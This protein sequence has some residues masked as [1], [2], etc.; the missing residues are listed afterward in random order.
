M[1]DNIIH[2]E[3]NTDTISINE[4][5]YLC[6]IMS[7]GIPT[8]TILS[9][10]LPGLGATTL[11]IETKRHSIIIEPNVPVIKGKEA[12]HKQDNLLGVYEGV[13]TDNVIDY[14]QKP[15]PKEKFKKIMTTPESFF[16]IIRAMDALGIDYKRDYM[17][18]IDECDK[19]IQDVD[20]RESIILPI[21]DFFL[22]E[23]KAFVSATPLLPSDPRFEQQN[24]QLIKIEPD[25]EYRKPMQLITT[26]NVVAVF[27][28][29][30]EQVEADKPLCIF[31]NS[32]DTIDAIINKFELIAESQVFCSKESVDKLK[33]RNS[34]I[35]AFPDLQLDKNKK[36]KLL[37]YNFF[38]SR[39]FSAVDIDLNVEPNVIIISDLF[40]AKHSMIDPYTEAIQIVGRFRNGTNKIIHLSNADYSLQS[41]TEEQLDNYLKGCHEVYSQLKGLLQSATDEGVRDTL[42]EALERVSYAKYI[43][44]YG[45]KKHFSIDNLFNDERIKGYYIHYTRLLEAYENSTFFDIKHQH[46]EIALGDDDR[47]K[48]SRASNKKEKRLLIME[49]LLLLN[50]E[51]GVYDEPLFQDFRDS[52]YN[53][54]PLFVEVFEELGEEFA[55]KNCMSDK[56]MKLALIK[57][58]SEQ[59]RDNFAIMTSIY[60][61]FTEGEKYTVKYI[62]KEIRAIFGLYGDNTP[63][64]TS[65]IED[66]FICD[67]KVY[68]GKQRAYF[69]IKKLY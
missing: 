20:Y 54:D 51:N 7:N 43:D 41:K 45:N 21:E 53:E 44:K 52:F 27:R 59:G 26:N 6:K 10:T 4:G 34:K 40:F 9:K 37:K 24:F 64:P 11:E 39:F 8:N 66:Y 60:A 46:I 62:K 55:L 31:L 33:E 42:K 61:T 12:K 1:Q 5:E 14:L 69:L 16:K 13:T 67:K 57:Y 17:L 50:G 28:Q 36:T 30:Q 47:L 65:K 2:F 3:L 49:Q 35:Q 29:I 15:L 68:L 19:V 22:F 18:L 23:N 38:T 25:F 32:T 48:M 58:R 56:K 63:Y